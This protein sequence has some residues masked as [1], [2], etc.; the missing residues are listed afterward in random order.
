MEATCTPPFNET[1]PKTKNY[2]IVK[3]EAT[4]QKIIT[5]RSKGKMECTD[6]LSIIHPQ[7]VTSGFLYNPKKRKQHQNCFAFEPRGEK[8]KKS[9][10]SKCC[11]SCCRK[12]FG[13]RLTLEHRYL[14]TPF[15]SI[16]CTAPSPL[17]SAHVTFLSSEAPLRDTPMHSFEVWM[18]KLISS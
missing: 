6:Q 18:L 12:P 10:C 15:L 16:I 11:F 5:R 7:S 14:L 8:K 13:S 17:V 2:V 1:N 3:Y 4:A 9:R